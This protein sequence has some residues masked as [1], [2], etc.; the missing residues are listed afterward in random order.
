MRHVLITFL[1]VCSFNSCAESD[2]GAGEQL[3]H[4]PTVV[5][6]EVWHYNNKVPVYQ[7][8]LEHAG[9][10]AELR[11]AEA[12][13]ARLYPEF[14]TFSPDFAQHIHLYVVARTDSGTHTRIYIT[15]S[16]IADWLISS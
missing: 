11:A 12:T 15:R 5:L 13:V 2:F 4:A 16:I 3:A 10:T 14:K 9:D 1:L 6:T 8:D 7:V